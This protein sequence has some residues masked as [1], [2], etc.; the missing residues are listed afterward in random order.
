MYIMDITDD[1]QSYIISPMYIYSF[2]ENIIEEYPAYKELIRTKDIFNFMRIFPCLS[3]LSV[4]FLKLVHDP[5]E[6]SP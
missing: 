3:I 4:I 2:I 1:S 6:Y 5:Q